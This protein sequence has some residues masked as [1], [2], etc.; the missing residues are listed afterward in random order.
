MIPALPPHPPKTCTQDYKITRINPSAMMVLSLLDTNKHAH[1]CG[2]SLHRRASATGRS[3]SGDAGGSHR[4]PPRRIRSRTD[5]AAVRGALLSALVDLDEHSPERIAGDHSPQEIV[6]DHSRKGHS[7]ERGLEGSAG[8]IAGSST[9]SESQGVCTRKED[10][11]ND[12]LAQQRSG[13]A[14]GRSVGDIGGLGATP[15]ALLQAV[16]A[17]GVQASFTQVIS[18]LR[19]CQREGQVVRVAHGRYILPHQLSVKQTP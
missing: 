12:G 9:V 1:R 2:F 17:Q 5:A 13:R 18:Q 7:L 15:R 4:P 16:H 11:F 10:S 19:I 8:S 14:L 6:R 3:G